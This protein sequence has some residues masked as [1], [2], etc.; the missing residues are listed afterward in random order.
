MTKEEPEPIIRKYASSFLKK[1][2]GNKFN[3]E[4]SRQRHEESLEKHREKA[5]RSLENK[6]LTPSVGYNFT[7][8]VSHSGEMRIENSSS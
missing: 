1:I 7:N 6:S 3:V 2:D 5:K 8:Y 4:S